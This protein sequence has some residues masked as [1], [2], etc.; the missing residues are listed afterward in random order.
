MMKVMTAFA[1]CLG[2]AACAAPGGG[3]YGPSYDGAGINVDGGASAA[4]INS[5]A[6]RGGVHSGVGAGGGGHH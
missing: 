2:V 3:G 6:N 5:P 4:A 1:L